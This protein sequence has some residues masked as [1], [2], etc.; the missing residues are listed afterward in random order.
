MLNRRLDELRQSIRRGDQRHY[1]QPA[2][3]NLL[4]E[5]QQ[6]E[7]TWPRRAARLVSRMCEAE[8]PVILPGERILFTRT[9]PYVAPIYSDQEWQILTQHRRLHEMG[10]I[11][12]ICGLGHGH[13]TGSAWT[14][15]GSSV[16]RGTLCG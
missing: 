8:Q 11:S 9:L 12:N 16:R 3:P 14:Q 5:C 13:L 2:S 1:R 10:P 7:L 6:A 15:A 4:A